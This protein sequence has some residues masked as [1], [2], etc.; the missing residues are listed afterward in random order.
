MGMSAMTAAGDPFGLDEKK[1]P[2]VLERVLA[3]D[4]GID[5][6]LGML[7]LPGWAV[8]AVRKLPTRVAF[9]E[10]RVIDGRALTQLLRELAPSIVLL[11]KVQPMP[12]D[13]NE[14]EVTADG[15]KTG[16]TKIVRRHR[17]P[18]MGAFTYGWTCGAIFDA[19]EQGG[20]DPV[21]VHPSTW[22]AAA[23]LRASGLTYAQRKRRARDLASTYWPD[24]A[25][26]NAD[27]AEA[28]LLARFGLSSQMRIF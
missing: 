28:L 14:D 24:A 12:S 17:M 3:I 6:A 25:I 21:M 8:L 15:V 13:R 1:R 23:G 2:R 18:Q 20:H 10:R 5:G 19:I 16:E 26:A 22:K 27:C 9:D 11:E 7:S 4:P